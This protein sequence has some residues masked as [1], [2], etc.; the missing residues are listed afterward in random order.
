MQRQCLT[1]GYR[2]RVKCSCDTPSSRGTCTRSTAMVVRARPL[3]RL[4]NVNSLTRPPKSAPPGNTTWR[5]KGREAA[6][7][8]RAGRVECWAP[9]LRASRGWRAG[10]ART[11]QRWQQLASF[12]PQPLS[13]PSVGGGFPP[14]FFP[15]CTSKPRGERSRR[16]RWLFVFYPACSSMGLCPTEPPDP[17]PPEQPT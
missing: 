16:W 11:H 1:C 5:E 14:T 4:G 3:P 17:G 2:C 9:G 7:L 6:E 12:T 10:M 13:E 15:L 8:A